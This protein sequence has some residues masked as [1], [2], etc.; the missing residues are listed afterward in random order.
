MR[1]FCEISD[2]FNR[3]LYFLLIH[4]LG[5]RNFRNFF[6]Y[7]AFYSKIFVLFWLNFNFFSQNFFAFFLKKFFHLFFA[8]YFSRNF[9]IIFFATFSQYIFVTFCIFYL[10]KIFICLK[11]WR[12]FPQHCILSST[13]LHNLV[14]SSECFPHLYLLYL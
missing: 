8:L 3:Y 5:T 10:L 1:N 14:F 6:K 11:S 2:G 12:S 9:R 13:T 7:S 4:Q